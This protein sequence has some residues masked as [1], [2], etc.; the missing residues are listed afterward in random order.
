MNAYETINDILVHLFNEI[1]ELEEKA[2]ITEEFK[3]ISNNDMHIIEAVGLGND[4]TMSMV[5]RKLG[6]TAG[7]LTTSVNSLVNK[8]YLVRERSESD[9]RVVYVRLT[10][11]GRKAFSHH[12]D[13]HMQMTDA[14]VKSLDAEEIPVL[15]KTLNSLSEFFRGY[16]A[17]K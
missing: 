14:V 17:K 7:S 2:I 16:E 15:L 12:K 13:Y 6:I 3:D 10:E 5:A 11:K 8:K 9:R 1:W 4:S